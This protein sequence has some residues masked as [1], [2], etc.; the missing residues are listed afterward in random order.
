MLAQDGALPVRSTLAL[1]Q[2]HILR[3]PLLG[4]GIGPTIIVA[5]ISAI[6]HF[7]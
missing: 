1:N 3:C 6:A 2:E 4:A 5:L 7:A